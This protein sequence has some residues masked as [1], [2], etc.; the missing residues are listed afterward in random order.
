MLILFPLSIAPMGTIDGD[1]H[2]LRP[3]KDY[4]VWQSHLPEGYTMLDEIRIEFTE[5][6]S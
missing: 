1:P 6:A 3:A 5:E 4:P 2:I